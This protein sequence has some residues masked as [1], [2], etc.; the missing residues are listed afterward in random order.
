VAR[1]ELDYDS[2]KEFITATQLKLGKDVF[3][4]VTL[5]RLV[6]L[7]SMDIFQTFSNDL[8]SIDTF[9]LVEL[10]GISDPV[11]Q[12]SFLVSLGAIT[13]ILSYSHNCH[14]EFSAGRANSNTELQKFAD[15][16]VKAVNRMIAGS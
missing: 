15:M 9:G 12:M 16:H 14:F 1:D 3:T 5:N 11:Q 13:T 7:L 8:E 2:F 6:G 10:Y 4:D